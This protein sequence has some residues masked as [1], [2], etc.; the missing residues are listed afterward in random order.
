[1]IKKNGKKTDK[2]IRENS[3]HLNNLLT[4]NGKW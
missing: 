1:M 4:G 2:L 3:F